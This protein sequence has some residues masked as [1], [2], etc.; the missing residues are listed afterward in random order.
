MGMIGKKLA[1]L[2]VALAA[3]RLDAGSLTANI[4]KTI[5]TVDDQYLYVITVEGDLDSE[6]KLP[7]IE[8]L[9]IQRVGTSHQTSIVNG[10]MSQQ[11]QYTFAIVAEKPGSYQ[12]PEITAVVDGEKMQ[13]L[14]IKF[15]VK[16][17][18]ETPSDKGSPV[19]FLEETLSNLSPYAG[20]AIV[21]TVRIFHRTQLVDASSSTKDTPFIKRHR[22]EGEKTYT[23]E[24]NGETYRVIEIQEIL[25]PS[26]SGEIKLEPFSLSVEI[27]AARQRK[28]RDPF[29]FFDN[30]F[31]QAQTVTK[32][33]RG[34]FRTLKVK[35]LPLKDRP[36]NFSGLVG[37]FSMQTNS[38]AAEMNAQETY[39]LVV[40]L[41]GNN[42]VKGSLDPKINL[43]GEIKVYP[44]KPVTT[45]NL[46]SDGVDA[47]KVWKYALVP[48]GNGEVD[49]GKVELWTFDPASERYE[50]LSADLGKVVVTGGKAVGDTKKAE[51]GSVAHAKEKNEVTVVN[52][53]ALP[54]LHRPSSWQMEML[55][56]ERVKSWLWGPPLASG[57]MFC[58]VWF[59]RR[60]QE[61]LK[62][63]SAEKVAGRAYRMYLKKNDQL[64]KTAGSRTGRDLVEGCRHNF[65]DY[66]KERFGWETAYLT[67][68]DLDQKLPQVGLNDGTLGK[69]KHLW[70]DMDQ[71]LFAKGE[72]NPEHGQRFVQQM[73]EVAGE[74]EKT[75]H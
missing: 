50:L 45:E 6:P 18:G 43:P 64:S 36:A 27:P 19:I 46:S 4:D 14:P 53:D 39:D 61:W 31:N 3:A 11:V 16:E 47:T 57:L 22:I 63:R 38:L 29:S 21:N 7:S 54:G 51:E 41:T 65:Q 1:L 12:I 71:M 30:F 2:V 26:D 13:T 24:V 34:K 37:K 48:T 60:R 42:F 69:I 73:T 15:A 75:I 32:Q 25:V 74:I 66:L 33:V 17:G 23:Q 5:G 35:A 28:T 10:K 70:K 59:V 49:L 8:G 9:Q 68:K 58:L 52:N 67:L 55:D 56:K 20:E 44:E 62:T 40:T 72:I